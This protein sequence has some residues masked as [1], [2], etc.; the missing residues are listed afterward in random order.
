MALPTSELSRFK[1]AE[2]LVGDGK[3]LRITFCR[4]KAVFLYLFVLGVRVGLA[5]AIALDVGG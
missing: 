1:L 5:L 4:G 3:Q 2:C